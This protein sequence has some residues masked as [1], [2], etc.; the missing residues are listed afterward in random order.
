MNTPCLIVQS[1]RGPLTA[2]GLAQMEEC[3]ELH[4]TEALVTLLPALAGL[5]PDEQD[6]H[7]LSALLQLKQLQQA[8]SWHCPLPLVMLVPGPE[9]GDTHKVE[10]GNEDCGVEK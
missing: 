4:G 3:C 1:S 9:D 6:V 7:L 10:E 5:E 2:D 8:S